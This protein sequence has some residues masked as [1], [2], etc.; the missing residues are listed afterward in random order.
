MT[1]DEIMV[2]YFDSYLGPCCYLGLREDMQTD[3]DLRATTVFNVMRVL[4]LA[5]LAVDHDLLAHRCLHCP[6]TEDRTAT[7]TR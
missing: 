4:H 5:R 1:V 7:G 6:D 2:K 3:L